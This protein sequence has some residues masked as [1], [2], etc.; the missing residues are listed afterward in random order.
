M[1]RRQLSRSGD[2]WSMHNS[3][4][5]VNSWVKRVGVSPPNSYHQSKVTPLVTG[6]PVNVRFCYYPSTIRSRR[7]SVH[8]HGP[9]QVLV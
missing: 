5:Q 1:P 4:R 2:P 7:F 3:K 9:V 6:G 8:A